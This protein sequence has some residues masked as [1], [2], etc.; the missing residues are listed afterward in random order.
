MEL[1]IKWEIINEH[2]LRRDNVVSM[3]KSVIV[4]TLRT[5]SYEIGRFSD[6]I[7][8]KIICNK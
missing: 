2:F 5:N 1:E 6:E 4:L 8:K 7:L 3:P